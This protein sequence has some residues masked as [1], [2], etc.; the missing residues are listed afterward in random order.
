M[1][2]RKEDFF[3]NNFFATPEGAWGDG[4]VRVTTAGVLIIAA[5]IVALLVVAAI[6]RHK[7]DEKKA[8]LTTRQ[9]V[10][11]AMAI[12]LAMVCSM[13]KFADLP[14]GGSITLFSMLFIVLIG[15]WYGPYVGIM[16][17][18]AYGLLQFVMEP[19]FY[20]LPQMVI[21]YPCAFGALGLSGLFSGKKHGLQLGYIAGVLGRYVFAV[22][23][24]V[25]FFGAYA[26]EGMPALRYS[27]GYNASYLVPEAALT[28]VVICIP[29]VAHALAEVKKRALTA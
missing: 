9:L 13:I 14:M 4:S 22:I 26:P 18:V 7:N 28:L 27:L 25:V 5:L 16:T 15:Y 23:S 21:D 20:T 10:F 17:A 6:L 2:V 24:G 11:S 12:A 19:I 3:M 8:K 1:S 29:P